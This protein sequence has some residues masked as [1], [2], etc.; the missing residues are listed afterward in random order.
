MRTR[1]RYQL[2]L[3]EF[4]RLCCENRW[5]MKEFLDKS[6]IHR[7]ELHLMLLPID[8]PKFIGVGPKNRDRFKKTFPKADIKALFLPLNLQD[9]K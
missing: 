5:G 9:R 3:S 6:E 1:L 4:E 2:N 7:E 8:H